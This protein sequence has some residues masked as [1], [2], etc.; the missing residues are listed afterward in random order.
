MPGTVSAVLAGDAGLAV[1][2]SGSD[3]EQ[4]PSRMVAAMRIESDF[5]EEIF[6]YNAAGSVAAHSVVGK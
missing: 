5:M 4:A 3:F 1:E 6:Q 2:V